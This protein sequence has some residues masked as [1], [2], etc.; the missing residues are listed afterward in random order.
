MSE[1]AGRGEAVSSI[2]VERGQGKTLHSEFPIHLNTIRIGSLLVTAVHQ[3]GFDMATIE[4]SPCFGVHRSRLQNLSCQNLAGY[5][6][7]MDGAGY[8]HG[9]SL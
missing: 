8:S 3:G 2:H 6:I 5:D 4:T 7:A 1:Q 9:V